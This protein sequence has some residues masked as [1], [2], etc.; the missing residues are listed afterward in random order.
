[1]ETD[2]VLCELGEGHEGAHAQLL[3]TDDANDGAVWVRWARDTAAISCLPWCAVTGERGDACSL[4]LAHPAGHEWQ[5]T[6]PTM[7]AVDAYL[8]SGGGQDG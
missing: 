4:F 2:H 5:V 8:A 7:E 6:D 1:M 3:W